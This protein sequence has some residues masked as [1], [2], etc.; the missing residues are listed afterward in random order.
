MDEL[1]IRCYD[2]VMDV[3]LMCYGCVMDVCW[4]YTGKMTAN[5]GK[6]WV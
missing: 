2:R 6:L 3:L 1:S 4:R 5:R